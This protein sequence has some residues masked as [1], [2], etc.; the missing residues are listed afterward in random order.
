MIKKITC[1]ECPQGCQLEVEVEGGYVIK[2][3]GN[4]CPKGEP[5]AKQEIENPM[6]VLTST[7]LTEGLEMKMVAVR[8][9]KPIPK[10]KLFEAMAEVKKLRLKRPVKV[11]EI[12]L[13]DLL[14]TGAD[15]IAARESI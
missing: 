5:Y 8:T 1:I 12:I 6:R 2:V 4:K 15:L 13:S 3:T 14:G 7:V 11:G 9:N 10:S